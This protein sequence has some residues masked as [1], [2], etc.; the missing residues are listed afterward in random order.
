MEGRMTTTDIVEYLKEIGQTSK[1]VL[2]WEMPILNGGITTDQSAKAGCLSWIS[3]SVAKS[4]PERI[5]HF[6]GDALICPSFVKDTINGIMPCKDP[7]LAFAKVVYRFFNTADFGVYGTYMGGEN[8]KIGE[9]CAIGLDG[10][11]YVKDTDG[12]WLRFPHLGRV[13]IG[14]NV[15][16][17]SNVCIDRGALGDTTIGK[18]VKI[19]NL[20]HVAHNVEIGENTLVVAHSVIGGSVKIGKNVFVGMGAMI[21]NK[22]TVGDGATIGMGAVVIHDVPAGATVVGNP[23]RVLHDS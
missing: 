8:I 20:V 16:I 15:E 6:K 21:K 10:F 19:D 5:A 4:H 1:S 18:G 12:T 9:N 11:G 23:A 14:D 7:K 2:C 17:G 13:V 3:E 22:V